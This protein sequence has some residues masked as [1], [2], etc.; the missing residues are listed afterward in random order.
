MKK[1]MAFSLNDGTE[2]Q[3]DTQPQG[4]GGSF[5]MRTKYLCHL[6]NGK[7]LSQK[8]ESFH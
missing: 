7:F 5:L 8:G 2:K 6:M 1:K 4:S 3:I